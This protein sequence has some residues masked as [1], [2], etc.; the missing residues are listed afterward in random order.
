MDGRCVRAR[1]GRKA[2][3]AECA[4]S[5]RTAEGL[6]DHVAATLYTSR[7]SFST[8]T[9]P[10]ASESFSAS[11]Q[12]RNGRSRSSFQGIFFFLSVFSPAVAGQQVMA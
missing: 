2:D 11:G 12:G 6:H 1:Q 4:R 9:T 5:H 10:F 8:L 7:R 3:P